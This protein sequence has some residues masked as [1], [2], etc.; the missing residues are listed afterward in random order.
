MKILPVSYND[1][2]FK[3]FV[4]L[5]YKGNDNL[6]EHIFKAVKMVPK[7]AFFGKQDIPV[8]NMSDPA[9]FPGLSVKRC[10]ED[11]CEE[12]FPKFPRRAN[13]YSKFSL[14]TSDH[15]IDVSTVKHEAESSETKVGVLRPRPRLL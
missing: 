9:Q 4:H 8:P 12:R 1:S 13:D 3:D 14:A 11:K 10:A 2:I 15:H 6:V 7:S 5:T